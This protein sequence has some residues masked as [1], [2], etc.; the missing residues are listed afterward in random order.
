METCYEYLGCDKEDCIMHGRKD[1]KRCWEVDETLCCNPVALL[2]REKLGGKKE[3][4]CA[5][6]ACVYYTAAKGGG[7]VQ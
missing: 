1:N 7:I 2:A 3:D 4:S 6:S 5:R